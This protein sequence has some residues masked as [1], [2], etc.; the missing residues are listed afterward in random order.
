MGKY[1][2]TFLNELPKQT[3]FNDIEVVLDHNEPAKEEI[4]LVKSFGYS[5]IN[6][7]V[8]DKVD[9]IG[10]S[11]NRCINESKGEYLCIWNVDDLRTP[12]SIE[13]MAKTLDENPD[14]DFCYGNYLVVSSFGSQYGYLVDET[15]K[16]NLLTKGMVLGPFFMFRKS[17]IKKCGLFDEQLVSG[18]DFDLAL[19]LAFNGKGKHI[20]HILGFYLNEGMGA[21]TRPN[22]KQPLERTVIELRYGLSVLEPQYIQDAKKYNIENLYI[23]NN[24]INVKT[25]LPKLKNENSN[26]ITV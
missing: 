12:Y 20:P 17:A 8:V 22:S 1:L 5:N 11:M 6:H 3:I 26:F 13:L 18:A 10:V 4:D 21:S 16:E 24:K 2:K 9:P 23:N 14:V 25:F 15:G 7:I 19:R